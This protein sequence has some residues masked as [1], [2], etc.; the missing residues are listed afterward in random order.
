MAILLPDGRVLASNVPGLDPLDD[1]TIDPATAGEAPDSREAALRNIISQYP[2]RA[3]P[4]EGSPIQFDS[5]RSKWIGELDVLGDYSDRKL[6]LATAM[7]LG[8]FT[9]ELEAMQRHTLWIGFALLGAAIPIVGLV[10]HLITRPLRLLRVKAQRLE[11]FD[12]DTQVD[13]T[14][15]VSE[16]QALAKAL[17]GTSATIRRFKEVG[18]AMTAE[19]DASVLMRGLLTEVIGI[20]GAEGGVLSL[21]DSAEKTIHPQ[22]SAWGDA[23][24]AVAENFPAGVPLSK[25]RA[26]AQLA[27]NT[28]TMQSFVVDSDY[29]HLESLK[30]AEFVKPGVRLGM[31][32]QPLVGRSGKP[33]GLLSL[34]KR[35]N[36]GEDTFELVP[37]RRSL[38]EAVCASAAIAVENNQLVEQQAALMDGLIKLIAGAID[39]KSPYTAGHCQRV[40]VLTRLLTEAACAETTGPFSDFRLSEDEWRAVDVASWLHDCG[41][42]TTPEYIV[43]KATKLETI[44]DRIHEIRMRFEVLKRDAEVVY[45]RGIAAGG[46]EQVLAAERDEQLR[47]LDD[48][49]AFVAACNE[50]GEFMAPDKQARL[51]QIAALTWTRT[52]DDRLGVSR[53]ERVRKERVPRPILPVEEHVIIDRTDHLI[54]HDRLEDLAVKRDRQGIRLKPKKYKYNRGELYSLSISRGTLTEEERLEVNDHIVQTIAMLSDLPFPPHL[55]SVPELACGHHEKMDGTGYPRGLVR[56]EM[57]VV[58]RIMAVA[59]VFEAL[60]AADRPYKR[61]KTLSETFSIIAAMKRDHHL[62]PDLVDLFIQSGVWKIYAEEFLSPAQLDNPD[63]AAVLAIRPAP[64]LVAV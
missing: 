60:T 37:R 50:G 62:D 12:F 17:D 9:D 16:V 31:I 6:L 24:F 4:A 46:D 23:V 27:M 22:L 1:T 18:R 28:S 43:D 63:T 51:R 26:T 64:K 8:R 5:A 20:A 45:W 42:V 58:A 54:D 41:K 2:Q 61:A 34:Q 55:K 19:R 36:Q 49:F 59:D 35:L 29:E 56:D 38:V 53:D 30:L 33:I 11:G 44:Y 32:T 21:Y 3:I 25:A 10:A 40:P 15:S 13:V 39:A 7:P 47:S 52:L 48:D 57:S 14:S